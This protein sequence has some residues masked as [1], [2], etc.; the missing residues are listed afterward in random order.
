MHLK[1]LWLALALALVGCNNDGKS[2][3]TDDTEVD[4][5][6]DERDTAAA[7]DLNDSIDEAE[8]L[9]ALAFDELTIDLVAEQQINPAGDRDFFAVELTEGAPYL[10]WT[11]AYD[12]V[13]DTVVLDTVLRVYDENGDEIGENDDMIFRYRETDSAVFVNA[14]YTGTYYLEVLEFND[15]VGESPEGTFNHEYVLLGVR[16]RITEREG[17]NETLAEVLVVEPSDTD[18]VETDVADDFLYISSPVSTFASDFY[19]RMDSETDVDW[20]PLTIGADEENTTPEDYTYLTFSMWPD[21][22]TP[23]KMELYNVDGELL[24]E[25]T[26]PVPGINSLLIEDVGIIARATEGETYYLKVT[27]NGGGTGMDSLYPGIYFNYLPTLGAP[28]EEP[29]N[30]LLQPNFMAVRE[31]TTTAGFYSGGSTGVLPNGDTDVIVLKNADVDG[32]SGKFLTVVVRSTDVGSQLDA[33]ITLTTSDG[34]ELIAASVDAELEDHPDPV[35][36][37]YVPAANTDIYITI[38]ADA[39]GAADTANFWLVGIY[40]SDTAL[41]N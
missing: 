9:S 15:W 8:D 21:A 1:S 24:G 28:E 41:F 30:T 39:Y 16:M 23:P 14:T 34:T 11:E 4:E 35:I 10:F 2:G 6:P 32:L 19:G 18:V 38:E 5:T 27:H 26:D 12:P 36:R 33:K 22:I 7:A 31:S 17:A 37:D 3:E 25:T 13:T 40:L 20:W 29:N